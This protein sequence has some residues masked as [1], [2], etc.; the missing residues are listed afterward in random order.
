MAFRH[1]KQ[2][3]TCENGRVKSIEFHPTEPLLAVATYTGTVQL[4][5]TN[6]WSVLRVIRIDSTKP[7]RCVRWMPSNQWVIATGDNLAINAY[8]Y[9]NGS[10][11]ASLPD[12]HTDFIR[13][14][15]VHPSQPLLLSCSD[16]NTVKSFKLEKGKIV[17]D[18]EYKGHEHFVMDIKF[19]PKDP[20]TFATASL[21]ESIKFWGLGSTKPRFTLKGHQAGV[22]CIE[23]FPGA[24]KPYI[25][26]GGD[27]F[28][29]K[30]WDYQTKSC[31]ATLPGHRGN[32]TA[33][34]FHPFFPL[35]MSTSE[36]EML[37]MWNS[38]TFANETV[39]NY[40]KQRGW[41]IDCKSN[42]VS[43]GFDNGLV[44][45]QLG[46]SSILVTMDSNGKVFWAK[47]NEIQSANLAQASY[48]ED[49]PSVD[50]SAKDVAT[51]EIYP[52]S[53]QFNTTGRFVAICGENEYAIYS[54][55]AWRSKAFGSGKEFAWGVGDIYAIRENADAVSV[56]IGFSKKDTINPQFDCDRIFGGY[57]LG[58]AGEE[59]ICFYDWNTL[60]SI[61][62]IDV[63]ATNVWWSPSNSFVAIATSD[64][65]FVLEYNEDASSPDENPNGFQVIFETEVKA[66]SGCWFNE[67][68]FYNDERTLFF[69][70]GSHKEVLARYEKPLTIVGFVSKLERV[71]LCDSDYNFFSFS[72]PLVVLDSIIMLMRGEETL[73]VASIPI[74]WKPKVCDLLEEMGHFRESLKLADS[75]EKQF[76]LALKIPDQEIAIQ[77]ARKTG[78][79]HYWKQISTL[80][81]KNGQ[82]ELLE[83]SLKSSGDE[84]GLLL[85]Y[86]CSG[87]KEKLQQLSDQN[88]ESK[89]VQF[90]A[91]FATKNYEKC[92]D[93]LIS[94]NKYPEASLM[95]R[96]YLPAKMDECAKKWK[97]W[98]AEKGD[99]RGAES[100][101]IP[102]EYPNLFGIV[103][104]DQKVSNSENEEDAEKNDDVDI[105][106]LLGDISPEE[107][108]E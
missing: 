70:I 65:L 88:I 103:D 32:V 97:I 25:A 73:D 30:I 86:S 99:K 102:S 71:F 96:T 77:I 76:E 60:D 48:S 51:S 33:L 69:S 92:I 100:I 14:L 31:I 62:Q 38:Q 82:I 16:D 43:V 36:D 91:S 10:L 5:N 44:V 9:N 93:L 80:A 46:R 81:M 49:S 56:N 39:L 89:N 50:I 52:A 83:E 68:F 85:L 28:L 87:S 40:R 54:T 90:A 6:D 59:A 106:A 37:L 98:L 75:D 8:D 4:I 2:L 20:N 15:A 27:D 55:L 47:N 72:I 22:N 45:L 26:S 24:D 95:A 61:Q 11:V 17:F 108:N 63:K 84:S 64:T 78:S 1:V 67:V 53:V 12:A 3:M 104:Q 57:L 94:Q 79:M 41:A 107:L 34:R 13:T 66:K 58:V 74:E 21:D 7:T 105:D 29:I 18:K 42:T 19:N 101:A 23:F 35:L